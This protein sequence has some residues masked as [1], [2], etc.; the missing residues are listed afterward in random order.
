[1][2]AVCISTEALA[3]R[4]GGA[5]A[6]AVHGGGGVAYHGGTYRGGAAAYRGGTYR[7]SVYRNGYR[8]PSVA[9]GVGATAIGAAAAGSYNNYYNNYND[10]Y[11]SGQCGYY[12]Y[13]P[14]Y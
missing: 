8:R 3:Y 4:G 10:T 1:M 14:C 7:G 6:G 13:P 11:N 12:P 9:A 2:G 5:R